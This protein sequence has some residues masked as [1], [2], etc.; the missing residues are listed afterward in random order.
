MTSFRLHLASSKQQFRPSQILLNARFL[1][2]RTHFSVGGW[3]SRCLFVLFM[4]Q[5]PTQ[6]LQKH[7]Y[8]LKAEKAK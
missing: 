8:E 7:G 5:G 3:I 2:K 6:T 4:L 1:V